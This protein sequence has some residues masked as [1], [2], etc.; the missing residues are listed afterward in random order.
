MSAQNMEVYETNKFGF[1]EIT[2]SIIIDQNSNT[3][4]YEVFAV[5]KFGFK[6]INPDGFH[7]MKHLKPN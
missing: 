3:G 6:E 7:M 2:P 1:K 5:N 4:D